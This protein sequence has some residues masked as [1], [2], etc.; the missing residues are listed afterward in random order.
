MDILC[1]AVGTPLHGGEVANQI[2][3][4]CKY[5]YADKYGFPNVN[6]RIGEKKKKK[7]RK[8]KLSERERER[9]RS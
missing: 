4:K 3:K 2:Q 5:L 9:D 7:I 1:Q 6:W 8:K